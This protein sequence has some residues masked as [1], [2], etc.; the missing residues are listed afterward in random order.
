M[1]FTFDLYLIYLF[2]ILMIWVVYIGHK[3][4]KSRKN[5]SV[6]QEEF[7]AGLTEPASLHPLIDPAKCMGCGT[8]V[9][10]CP[11]QHNHRLVDH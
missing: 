11:E 8:C 3:R 6:M 2:P 1:Q 4:L 9:K 10:A 7:D 5:L